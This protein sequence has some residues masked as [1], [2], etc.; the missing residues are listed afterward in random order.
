[1]N[2]APFGLTSSACLRLDMS[3]PRFGQGTVTTTTFR[4]LPHPAG[5]RR[6]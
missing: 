6:D 3:A 1:M 4:T 2:T 5:L